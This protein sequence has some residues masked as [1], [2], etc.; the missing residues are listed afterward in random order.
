M[1]VTA[2]L[3]GPA[4]GQGVC[5][6]APGRTLRSHIHRGPA[7]ILRLVHLTTIRA[8]KSNLTLT[9]R[10]VFYRGTRQL[11]HCRGL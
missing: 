6:S 1:C 2:P 7:A 3:G 10:P 5:D 11:S 8:V 4:E 9:G